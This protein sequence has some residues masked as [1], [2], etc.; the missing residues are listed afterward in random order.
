MIVN[1]DKPNG[2]F[3]RY[4]VENTLTAKLPK[5]YEI[6]PVDFNDLK[7]YLHSGNYKVFSEYREFIKNSNPK[8]TYIF[9]V[10]SYHGIK[11]PKLLPEKA[12]I[13]CS[14]E[15]CDHLQSKKIKVI[16]IPLLNNNE[17][18]IN[19]ITPI[20]EREY[21]CS[22]VGK[23]THDI[24]GEI[25]KLKWVHCPTEYVPQK[26]FQRILSQSV[27]TLAPRGIN[28]SSYRI[29]EALKFGSIPVYISDNHIL[30]ESFEEYGIKVTSDEIGKMARL[31]KSMPESKLI[32]LQNNGQKYFNLLFTY[33]GLTNWIL[34][35]IKA[36]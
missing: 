16:H 33:E 13:F 29:C 21:L 6:V 5:N 27:F 28:H 11:S 1:L 34:N 8:T 19:D 10:D 36:K 22:F 32:E 30:P 26:E 25:A 20:N 14:N 2:S 35:K 9:V 31:F 7:P 4:F 12:I 18:H 15:N 3:A 17:T 24:R 23:K